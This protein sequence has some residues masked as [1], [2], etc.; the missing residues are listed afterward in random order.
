MWVLR[1]ISPSILPGYLNTEF[2]LHFLQEE[3]LQLLEDVPLHTRQ[4]W[5][6]Q[7]DGA[8]HNFNHALTTHIN[9]QYPK[10][11]IDRG[12]LQPRPP[13]SPYLSLIE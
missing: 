13:R 10:K 9:N 2:Y 4:N 7:H 3:L 6:L 11:C 12:G 8:P 5:Y 1:V